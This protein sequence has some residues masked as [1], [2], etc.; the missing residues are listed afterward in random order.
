M[1][2]GTGYS[3]WHVLYP[4]DTVQLIRLELFLPHLLFARTK[5]FGDLSDVGTPGYIPNPVVKH[6]SAD[7]TRR[8]TSR[9]S[10]SLPK[11]FFCLSAETKRAAPISGG[12]LRFST[13]M[14]DL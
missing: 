11:D 1:L 4:K 5:S 6:V 7:G 9:E 14:S 8:V 3:F 10:R 2:Q 12:S 13:G